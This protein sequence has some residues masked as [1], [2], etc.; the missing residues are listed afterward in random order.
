MGGGAYASD[1]KGY[2]ES[3]EG[4]NDSDPSTWTDPSTGNNFNQHA[5]ALS[6]VKNEKLRNALAMHK[7]ENSSKEQLR[8]GGLNV[9]GGGFVNSG[10][11]NGENYSNGITAS[12]FKPV[13]LNP[14]DDGYEEAIAANPHLKGKSIKT[15]RLEKIN[16]NVSFAGKE[17]PGLNRTMGVE[18]YNNVVNGYYDSYLEVMDV[19][20]DSSPKQLKC[21]AGNF[22]GDCGETKRIS[23]K[24]KVALKLHR[25]GFFSLANDLGSFGVNHN[26]QP[27]K[28]KSPNNYRSPLNQREEGEKITPQK[29][30]DIGP[31][32]SDEHLK[33]RGM[34]PDSYKKLVADP[35]KPIKRKSPFERRDRGHLNVRK[36]WSPT[37]QPQQGQPTPEMGGEQPMMYRSPLHQEHQMP[38]GTMMPGETHGETS[39]ME[40]QEMPQQEMPQQET[41]WSKMEMYGDAIKTQVDKFVS[42][43]SYNPDIDKPIKSIQNQEWVGKITEW[44][45]EKKAKLVEAKK[46][47]DKKGE[48][49]INKHVQALIGDITTYSGKFQAWQSRNGGDQTPGNKGGNMTSEGS[50]KDKRFET[51]LAFVGDKNTS[52]DITDEGKVGIKS[53]GLQDL[54]YVEDLDTD[55]F[56]KD[57]K[58]YQQMLEM[59]GQLKEDAES[60]RPL[61]KNIIGG[62]ADVLLSNKDSLLSWA[63]DPLYGQAWVQ[64]FAQGNPGESLDWAMPESEEFD[65]DRLEDEVHGWLTDKLTQ[66][67]TKYAPKDVKDAEGIKEDTMASIKQ[68]GYSKNSPVA[69]KKNQTKA[70]QLIAKYS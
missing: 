59:S 19:M 22:T 47:K 30:L 55:V 61:N 57:F 21:F 38:D 7:V 29:P 63:H 10:T 9:E 70:Q 66:S 49:D 11:Y 24:Q 48:Q 64:D 67:Y 36:K 13:V 2:N 62:Q 56:M 4:M 58:G 34:N 16:L 31:P 28:H 14:G 54:K 60:G 52:M 32:Y 23:K 50:S 43:S 15:K 17:I 5:K 3:N 26:G 12:S 46:S 1:R 51:D 39:G 35:P 27:F 20:N 42:N 25:Q 41:I 33:S 8:K 68:D 37:K 45:K 65:K 18:E 6:N 40:G 69:Y 53:Y 44:L